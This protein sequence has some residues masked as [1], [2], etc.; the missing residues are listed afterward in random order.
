MRPTLR[1]ARLLAVTALLLVFVLPPRPI[2]GAQAAK[3]TYGG[4]LVFAVGGTPPSFDGHR[5]TTFAMLH[6]LAPHYSTLLRFDP[7]AYPKIVGDVAEDKW[8]VSR[9]G[10]TYTFKIRKGI[11]FHDGSDLTSK[12]VKATY[13]KIIFPP[14]GVAS[15]RQASYGVVKSIEAPDPYTIVFQLKQIS[16]SFIANLASPWNFIYKA[17]ILAKDPRWYEK[18]V[19]GSGP[20]VFVEHVPGSYWTGRKNPNYFM[21]DRPYLDT[22]KAI[23]IRDTAPRVAAVRSG[24]AL[25]EFRGFNPAA[26]EDIVRTLGKEAVVQESPW[27]CN[28]TVTIN[29]EKK[30]FN[31]PRVRRALTLAI[32]RWNASKA[33]SKISLMKYVGGVFR[34]GSQFATPESELVKYAGFGKNIEASRKEA[35]ALLKA[36]GVPDGFSF[37]LKNRNVK[38]P[39]EVT[40]IYTI[41]QWRQIGLNVNHVMQEEGPYFNDLRQ[42][43][44]DAAIDFACDFM[45]E[46]D[47]QLQKFLSAKKSPLNYG[48]YNDEVLDDLYDR[49]SRLTDKAERLKILRQFEKRVLDE[50]AYQ[51]HIL[52][53]QRI[54]PHWSKV[55]GWKVTPSHYVNQDLRDVYLKLY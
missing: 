46:P 48:R 42:G 38:E 26:Q 2:M 11:K 27:I 14:E 31:D 5:E 1:N 25:I 55:Q 35:R 52:W 4:E 34:P 6:P 49:Q 44:Y 19:M 20:F 32:D 7:Q 17:D 37:T 10:L 21:K 22:F 28:L 53:W 13:D 8:T 39:Y 47:L 3:P 41:D 15:A 23:F 16:A 54:V 24:Q 50:Q 9:D 29:A 12:D 40:G 36:A 30:P 33:L 43:N 45:D 51:F 18:N